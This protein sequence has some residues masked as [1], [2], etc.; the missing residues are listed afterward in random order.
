MVCVARD[1]TESEARERELV[2][3]RELAESA[4]RAKS[5]FLAMMSH[6][7][8][9]PLNSVI[10]FTNLLRRNKLG[11]LDDKELLYLEKIANNGIHLL[12]LI[13][14][15][16]DLS[17][18]EAGHT[19]LDLAPVDLTE[20]TAA[21]FAEIGGVISSHRNA[22][23]LSVPEG[24]A[25]I[26]ADTRRLKQIII[27][28]VGN[29]SKFTSRGQIELRVVEDLEQPG[30]AARI[31]IVD[32]GIGIP[33]SEVGKVF[34]SF[35]QVSEG[36]ARTYGGTGLGLAI[37]R[38]LAQLHGFELDV[39][40]VDG[41]G[42]TF[43]MKLRPGAPTPEHDPPIFAPSVDLEAPVS[44]GHGVTSAHGG[45]RTVPLMLLIEGDNDARLLT[46]KAV[47]RLGAQVVTADTGAAGF[48]IA[49]ALMP[50]LILL[51]LGLPD[52]HGRETVRRLSGDQRLRHVPVVVFSAGA[53]VEGICAASVLERPVTIEEITETLAEHLGPR[54]RALVVDDDN[55][56][57]EMLCVLLHSL[58][59]DTTQAGDGHEALAS[60]RS[61]GAD[62]VLLDICMPR[63]T[64]FE[65]L[66]Q[67]RLDPELR[68]IPVVVCTALD[69][70][71]TEEQRVA[72]E[73]RVV[74]RK[75]FNLEGRLEEAIWTLFRKTARPS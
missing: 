17:K 1:I 44:V 24:L 42:A 56:T 34:E 39:T 14:D 38:S 75:G 22:L 33:A 62:L 9:T 10:G 8:R 35:R 47:E 48:T 2:E 71:P 12:S 68:D 13:N 25:P 16:L 58:G 51:D 37:S 55:D 26:L 7:L 41:E 32:N 3:A 23:R 46:T 21:V 40:S 65:F 15:L 49:Q 29:A 59:V 63:M 45:T 43:Y 28:L 30:H 72:G 52:G 70:Q 69:L 20:L 54:R 74:I 67:L 11:K 60:L 64:G 5:D 61:V 66:E 27:N 6:E 31:D 73:D 36:G 53:D 4:N 19:E 50:D 57:C 18:I